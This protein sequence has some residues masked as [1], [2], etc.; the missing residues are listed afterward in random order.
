[1]AREAARRTQCQNN[2]KQFGLAFQNHHDVVKHLPTGGRGWSWIG[3]PDFGFGVDQPGGWAFNI[4]P[5][6]EGKNIYEIA[7]GKTGIL[8]RADLTRM[9]GTPI[10]FFNCPSRRPAAVYGIPITNDV[11]FNFE[12]VGIGAKIDYSANS[13][14][15]APPNDDQNG[16]GGT[17]AA[18]PPAIPT[19]FRFNGV[20]YQRSTVRLAEISDG[21]SNT[22]MVGE[23][24]LSVQNYRTG[25]DQ[26]DNENLY[27]GF[28]NDTT[29]GMNNKRTGA[30]GDIRFPPR[31]DSR[32]PDLR[33]FGSAHPSGFN[34]VM[35]D[36]AVR[37]I[38]YNISEDNYMRLGNRADGQP[39]GEF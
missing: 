18:G 13:G 26:A 33:T 9:V 29:R 39:L 20:V 27:V 23:K 6:C 11:F 10:K 16:N 35:C 24:H 5:F 31:V 30:V 4:L 38:S 17:A 37:N 36:G 14:D 22:L 28:D 25:L 2:L 15:Q 34:A 3:D 12:P 21:T 19:A 32:V 8:K 1:M 7:A